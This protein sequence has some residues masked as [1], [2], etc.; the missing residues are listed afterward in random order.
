MIISWADWFGW[1]PEI[2]FYLFILF[3]TYTNSSGDYEI[4]DLAQ[5]C[6]QAFEIHCSGAFQLFLFVDT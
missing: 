2:P 6:K 4:V 5:V 1:G 3:L